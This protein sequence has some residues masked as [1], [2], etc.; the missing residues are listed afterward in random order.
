ML[1]GL[2]T[3]VDSNHIISK[4]NNI[5]VLA[6][7]SYASVPKG[8]AGTDAPQ[9][10]NLPAQGQRPG[11]WGDTKGNY[12]LQ[13]QHHKTCRKGFALSGRQWGVA[14]ST[15]GAA[16]G[17]VVLALQADSVPAAIS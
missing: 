3:L 16:L 10:Q 12:A 15:Q 11:R 14:Y 2:D 6:P 7:T 13:G 17:C 8:R 1:E 5:A 4:G 9:G